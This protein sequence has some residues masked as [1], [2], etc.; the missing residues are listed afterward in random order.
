ME[1]LMDLHARCGGQSLMYTLL[2]RTDE[3]YTCAL[4]VLK[5]HSTNTHGENE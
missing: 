2:A 3:Y 5:V 4:C 1:G